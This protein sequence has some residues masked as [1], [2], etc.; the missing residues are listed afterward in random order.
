MIH[1]AKGK[2]MTDTPEERRIA[3]RGLDLSWGRAYLIFSGDGVCSATRRDNGR[4]LTAETPDTLRRK[5]EQDFAECPV[6]ED[7]F[8]DQP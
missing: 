3:V 4:A 6:P 2:R 8:E 1:R 7:A 5:I